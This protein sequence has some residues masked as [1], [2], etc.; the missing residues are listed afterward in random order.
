MGHFMRQKRVFETPAPGI[1]Y[2]L[3]VPIICHAFRPPGLASSLKERSLIRIDVDLGA[4]VPGPELRITGVADIRGYAA[5][6]LFSPVQDAFG[7]FLVLVNLMIKWSLESSFQTTACAGARQQKNIRT[8]A[9]KAVY[10]FMSK[11]AL[12]PAFLL[13]D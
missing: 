6:V 13:L 7:E 5:V 2:Y 3:L 1:A 10:L 4:L 12:T 8:V 9:K 11:I